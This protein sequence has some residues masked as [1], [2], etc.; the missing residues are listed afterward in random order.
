MDDALADIAHVEKRDPEIPTIVF[1]RLDLKCA[2]RIGDAE[3]PVG[4]RYIVVRDR[5]RS[6]G[7][8]GAASGQLQTFERLG[9]SHFVHELPV[10]IQQRGAVRL[11]AYHMRVPDFVE[12]CPATHTCSSMRSVKRR[13]YTETAHG[14]SKG[15]ALAVAVTT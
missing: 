3:T 15:I 8:P 11:R 2:H 6:T 1:Q 14:I 9:G 12:Q 5:E 10:D 13:H 4:R 7:A